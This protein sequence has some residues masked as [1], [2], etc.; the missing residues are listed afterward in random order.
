MTLTTKSEFH[1]LGV[2]LEP[3]LTM[4]TQVSAVVHSTH[5]HLW[6]IAQLHPYLDVGALTTLAQALVISRLDYCNAL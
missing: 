6:Q 2:H 5:F 3:A 1:S 4:D